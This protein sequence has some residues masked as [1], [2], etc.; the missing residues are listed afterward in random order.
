MKLEAPV[1]IHN[2]E[3]EVSSV[4]GEDEMDTEPELDTTD[5]EFFS[6]GTEQNPVLTTYRTMERR[7]G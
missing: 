7:L 3:R 6:L 2:T 4:S 5:R 1:G